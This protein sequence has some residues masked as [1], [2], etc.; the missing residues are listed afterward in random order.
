M[1]KTPKVIQPFPGEGKYPSRWFKAYGRIRRY[2]IILFLHTDVLIERFFQSNVE[3]N[4]QLLLTRLKII[5]NWL[6]KVP[7]DLS[8]VLRRLT[9][10]TRDQLTPVTRTYLKFSSV[11]YAANVKCIYHHYYLTLLVP[12]A[13][14]I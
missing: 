14:Q 9:K 5:C 2:K 7:R 12:Q 4:Q 13:S 10:L 1:N 6:K 3:S 11:H 8:K